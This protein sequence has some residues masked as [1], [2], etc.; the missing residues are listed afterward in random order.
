MPRSDLRNVWLGRFVLLARLT[1]GFILVYSALPKMFRP[2]EFLAST[3]AYGLVGPELGVIVA[4]VLPY[5]ELLVG[6]ALLTGMLAD[7]ALW[8]STILGAI[9]VIV[10]SSALIR[11]LVIT[12]GC[13]GRTK[14]V[15]PATLAIAALIFIASAAA[16]ICRLR[17]P[18]R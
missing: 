2:Y 7:G 17:Q 5:V 16:L 15:G 10:Q 3:Y 18:S 4:A 13:S 1:V 12:C 14:F 11:G 6:V 8:L 9:F